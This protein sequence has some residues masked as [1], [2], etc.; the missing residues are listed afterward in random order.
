MK[1]TA[2]R[3]G[4]PIRRMRRAPLHQKT[5]R[6]VQDWIHPQY[7]L[8]RDPLVS[9]HRL[10]LKRLPEAFAGLRVVQISDIHYGIFLSRPALQRLIEMTQAL[11]PD[12]IV[13]T[14]DFV[15]QSQV[16]I[17]PVCEQLADL[18]ARHGV[19]AV[20]GNH[21][22][23][24]GASQVT[25]ALRRHGVQ[26]LRNSHTHLE[27]GGERIRL[28][29]IDDS[30]QHPNLRV[31]LGAHSEREF[32]L[33][34]AH[35]PLV[36]AE[37]AEAGVDLVLSGHTHGGQIKFGFAAPLYQRFLPEGILHMGPTTMYVSRGVGKV[38]VPVRLGAPPELASFRLYPA[39]ESK[40][41]GK[42]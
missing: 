33:L 35:N 40:V 17:E 29:G 2:A 21:D 16:F 7:R 11:E 42:G 13:L 19:F 14:G 23:R 26:V 24:A 28:A 25:A 32:T 39:Q 4:G 34:L 5:W 6:Q 15:T 22:F 18:H 8:G 20:L 27:R 12:L 9:R 38:I 10:V 3:R 30:R 1:E 31:A 36:L 41:A 37:A